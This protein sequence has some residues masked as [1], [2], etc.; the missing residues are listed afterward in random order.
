[1]NRICVGLFCALVAAGA[2]A[3]DG[4]D[5]YGSGGGPYGSGYGYYSNAY[6][7]LSF[8]QLRYSEQGLN[9]ITPGTA[10]VFVGARLSPF[11]SV[12]GRLGGGLGWAD[13]NGYGLEVRSV[14]AGYLKG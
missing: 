13:T 11:V 6:V 3:R 12:E 10:S 9:A 7:G 8:G 5:P 14:F 1:M 2:S 4:Y